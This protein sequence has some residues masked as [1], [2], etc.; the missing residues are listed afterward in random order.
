MDFEIILTNRTM[1]LWQ[2]RRNA[3]MFVVLVLIFSKSESLK[4][5]FIEYFIHLYSSYM[6]YMKL[7]K[8]VRY[9]SFWG[10]GETLQT[11][12]FKYRFH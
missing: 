2:T 3:E 9:F 10:M 4:I 12:T 6:L 8:I 5:K 7:L 11:S 1:S